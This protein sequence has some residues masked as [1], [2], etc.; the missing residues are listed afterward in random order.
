MSPGHEMMGWMR[1]LFPICRSITGDGVRRTLAYLSARLPGTGLT[2]HEVP[3]GTR[4]F[5]WVVPREWNIRDAWLSDETGRRV[6]DFKD[7]NLHVVGYSTPVD[8]R[9]S[10]EDLQPHLH[11]LPEQPDAIPYVTSYY[12]EHWGF[13]LTE[14]QR[15]ALKPGRYHAVI[16]S[17][18]ADGALTYGELILPG[19]TDQEILLST[20][21]CH[22]S[23]A[24]NELSGPVVATALARWLLTQPQRR[25]TY[26]ILFAP[27]TIG[28][29]VYLSRHHETMRRHTVAGFVLTCMGDP[30]G[31]SLLHS[32]YGDTLADR[33]AEHVL[34]HRCPGYQVYSY[35]DRGSDER[36]YGAPGIDLPV[37][38]IMRSKYGTYPEYHTSLDSLALVSEAGLEGSFTVLQSCLEA[39][40]GNLVFRTTCLCEPQLGRRGLYPQLSTKASGPAVRTM[41]NLLAYADGTDDLLG[42]A[43][44]I[45]VP[46][47][48]LQPMARRMVEAGVLTVTAGPAFRHN[49][50]PRRAE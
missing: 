14:R 13:C 10:L 40:E 7:S 38:S 1:D 32:R 34:G 48:E 39:L 21:I 4:A 5:D 33:V 43:R 16:D 28:A 50:E 24:N 46:V 11:S 6:I 23:M 20:Y 37:V 36:Q 26:R 18:L 44:R 29:I 45:G 15:R 30:G 8:V 47:W 27:E 3:T 42:I 25:F 17:T 35:L 2:C 31:Y 19:S 12:R 41:M 22:P 49:D 9:L